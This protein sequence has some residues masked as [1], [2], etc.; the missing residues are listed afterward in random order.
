MTNPQ[1]IGKTIAE[2]EALPKKTRV[3][4]LRLRRDEKIIEF[5][6]STTIRADDVVAVMTHTQALMARGTMIGPEMDDTELL[7]FPQEMLDIVV[8][9][10][11]VAG[12]SFRELAA[13]EFARGVFL[14]K[15]L[16]WAN[17]CPLP[18]KQPLNGGMF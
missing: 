16:G 18:R 11:A 17:R 12:Q 4:I 5:E 3:F 13:K 9:S 6:T 7:D 14:Q 10:K 15:A 2:I 1:L 8:T